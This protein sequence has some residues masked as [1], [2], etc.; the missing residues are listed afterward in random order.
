[1]SR[2]GLAAFAGIMALILLS[3]PVNGQTMVEA[4]GLGA[5]AS[6]G[7]A[8]ARSTGKS[9]SGA[10]RKLDKALKSADST[11]DSKEDPPP[12]GS[13]PA[14]P[15][16]KQKAAA[17]ARSVPERAAPEAVAPQPQYEDA[18]GIQKG[19]GSDELLRRFGP[20]VMRI[21]GGGPTTTMTYLGKAGMVQV[22]LQGG[23]IASVEKPR[24]GG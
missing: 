6:N 18:A 20:P 11:T 16:P 7:A 3:S 19:M 2:S 8:G 15:A 4:A 1:M 10:F 14:H 12:A 5:A 17:E 9:I 24:S 22:E 21:A 23:K 13:K